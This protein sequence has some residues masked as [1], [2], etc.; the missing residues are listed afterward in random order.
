VRTPDRSLRVYAKLPKPLGEMTEDELD[1]WCTAF[2]STLA[3]AAGVVFANDAE[4]SP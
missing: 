4:E 1:E 3:E 2:V